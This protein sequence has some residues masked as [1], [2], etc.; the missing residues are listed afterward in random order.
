MTRMVQV[1]NVPDD[2][3]EQLQRRAAEAGMTLSTYLLRQLEEVVARPTRADVFARAARS[4]M[5]VPL[6]QAAEI[7]RS[8]RDRRS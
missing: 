5:S 8:E 7:V 6:A 1:R 3:H 4:G 2:V